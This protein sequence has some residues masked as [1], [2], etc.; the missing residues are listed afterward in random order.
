MRILIDKLA[1]TAKK[2]ILP[3]TFLIMM[4]CYANIYAGISAI[5][6]KLIV[7]T[8]VSIDQANLDKLS[9]KHQPIIEIVGELL[10]AQLVRGI[11][12]TNSYRSNQL[13][14]ARE[15]ETDDNGFLL[16]PNKEAQSEG[17]E[18]IIINTAKSADFAI[19]PR[20]KTVVDMDFAVSINVYSLE[21]SKPSIVHSIPVVISAKE[22]LRG[23]EKQLTESVS[24]L[25]MKIS[26]GELTTPNAS[27]GTV[28]TG[29]QSRSARIFRIGCFNS[30]RKSTSLEEEEFLLRRLT[31]VLPGILTEVAKEQELDFQ[32]QGLSLF[33]YADFC[34]SKGRL[35]LQQLRH[36]GSW[37]YDYEIF[38]EVVFRDDKAF[39]TSFIFSHEKSYKEKSI[40]DVLLRDIQLDV[41]STEEDIRRLARKMMEVLTVLQLK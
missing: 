30:A 36:E 13:V 21:S 20:I 35:S 40:T 2:V 16:Y 31:L 24:S 9:E 27:I 29:W 18:E 23:I 10:E 22:G 15:Y 8:P 34:L 7:L 39:L 5:E 33:E 38:G 1:L 19:L 14:Y 12:E 25:V 3:V 4:V 28:S 32:F 6:N 37:F 26:T 11:Y 17:E 41:L